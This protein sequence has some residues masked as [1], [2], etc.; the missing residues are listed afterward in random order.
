MGHKV[1][2]GDSFAIAPARLSA[3]S[4]RTAWVNPPCCASSQA[5]CA[6]ATA[7]C[8]LNEALHC[9]E[10][11]NAPGQQVVLQ[12]RTPPRLQCDQG[13]GSHNGGHPAIFFCSSSFSP[14]ETGPSLQ[15]KNTIPLRN[16]NESET[17]PDRR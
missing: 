11:T 14:P 7:R 2:R 3:S 12:L 16:G 6:R 4:E 17:I 13:G 10:A 8:C 15:G 9:G 1:L 5:M